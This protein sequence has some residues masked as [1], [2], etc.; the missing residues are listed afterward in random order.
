[1]KTKHFIFFILVITSCVNQISKNEKDS[2][3]SD[4]IYQYSTKEGLLTNQYTGSESIKNIK[5]KGDF[6]LGTFNR[7]DGEM[8]IF[9]GNVY[10][11]TTEGKINNMQDN[12]LSPFVV[13]KFFKSD[14]SFS[15]ENKIK[16]DSLKHI[17]TS[18]LKDI[19]VPVAVKISAKFE[20]LKSRSVNKVVDPSTTLEEIVAK[21]VVFDFKNVE[22]KIIGFWYPKYFDGVNFPGFHF[23]ALTND[24]SGGGHLLDCMIENANVEIDYASGVEINF[25]N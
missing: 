2:R 9:D 17:L 15:I 16:L 13:T 24:L 1:M 25:L 11:V 12:V 6:G 10:Q 20:S 18:V 22:G 23:H 21:Q 3:R 4:S 7:V 8:V 5:E 14:T 19:S